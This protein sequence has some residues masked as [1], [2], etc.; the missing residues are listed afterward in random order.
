MRKSLGFCLLSLCLGVLAQSPATLLV[1]IDPYPIWPGG[2]NAVITVYKS[3]WL[4]ATN[5]PWKPTTI[6]PATRTNAYITVVGGQTYFFRSTGT[7][8]PWGESDPS[9]TSTNVVAQ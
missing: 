8:Q 1:T 4:G 2:S 7:V 9:T 6:F 5:T 3:T